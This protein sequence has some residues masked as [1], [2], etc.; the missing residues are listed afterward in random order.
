MWNFEKKWAFTFLYTL[1]GKA[2]CLLKMG[3]E[4]PIRA[5]FADRK[6]V[7]KAATTPATTAATA[8]TTDQT[9][10]IFF[11]VPAGARTIRQVQ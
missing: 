7:I 5:A 11:P 1:G 9:L 3:K 4:I 6:K 2:G 10:T 8:T